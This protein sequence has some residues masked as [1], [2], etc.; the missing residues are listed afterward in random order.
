M[1]K[2]F[3]LTILLSFPA[4]ADNYIKVQ[5]N[6]EMKVV[7]DMGSI[8]FTA[9]NQ[10]KNQK[11]AVDKTIQQINSL[12][13]SIAKLKLEK[14]ELKNTN[15]SVYPVREYEKDKMVDKGTRAS[16]T[17]EVTTSAIAR[18][19]EVM[20]LAAKGDIQNVG[21]LQTFLSIEESQK[22][23]SKCLELAAHDAENKAKLLAKRL[24]VKL[25][26]AIRISETPAPT[27]PPIMME[28]NLMMKGASAETTQI[29]SGTQKFT[30]SIEVRFKIQ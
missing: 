8:S 21:A 19:G 27:L 7:P 14:L 23:Y 15:Y 6:C 1:R 25:G 18:I 10:S 28:R 20:A 11:E 4:L 30:A 22:Q 3:L 5:G 24:D 26:D 9:E 2:L 16:L 12:K 13:D 29:E 17:L